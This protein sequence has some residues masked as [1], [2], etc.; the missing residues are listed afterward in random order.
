MKLFKYG[1]SLAALALLASCA[2]DNVTDPGN[3]LK[4]DAASGDLHMTVKI[5]QVGTRTS[6]EFFI[7]PYSS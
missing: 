1:M 3:N 5:T 2:N 6:T 7:L 4:P